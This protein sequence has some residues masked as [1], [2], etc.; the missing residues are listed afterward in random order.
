MNETLAGELRARDRKLHRRVDDLDR[1]TSERLRSELDRVE[2]RAAARDGALLDAVRA[3]AADQVETRALLRARDRQVHPPADRGQIVPITVAVDG[4]PAALAAGVPR[5]AIVQL[6]ACPVCGGDASTPVCEY[7]KLLLLD[8]AVDA[9]AAVYDYA[10]CHA[11]GVVSARQRPLGARYAWLLDRFEL[12][13]GR[14][15]EGVPQARSL[16]LGS[17]ALSDADRAEL[18]A[19]AAK[20]VFVSEHL[21]LAKRQFLPALQKDR[22]ANSV[23]VEMIGSLLPLRQ[24]RVLELRPRLGSIGAAL[25]R[26]YDARVFAMPL[27]EGQ[28][29]LIQEVYGIPSEHKVDYDCFT[30]PYEGQFDLIVA[31]HMLTHVLRPRQFLATLRERLNP[32]GCLYLYNEADE[33]E[34][35][36]GRSS[37]INTLNA[38]HVQTFDASSLARALQSGGFEPVF[39]GRH[40]KTLIGV[41]RATASAPAW[42][43][44]AVADLE[45]RVGA[46]AAARDRAILRLPERLRGRF[47]AEWEDVLAR[48]LARGDVD[49]DRQGRM[50]LLP[51]PA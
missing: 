28:Q 45:R 47:G 20:G 51:S 42:E 24:P 32:G 12:A 9:E 21:G 15:Q 30:I 35:L 25:Q 11:C 41:A 46:Y 2:Q 18:R 50:R 7:N 44:M 10:V 16:V 49:I 27:F 17:D 1:R 31:N 39:I 19:R 38:F 34:Y 3:L 29:F 5:D 40:D 22:M 48:A 6:A 43:P 13:L 33:G 36:D 23:H 37:M 4:P 14:A 26:L 8:T